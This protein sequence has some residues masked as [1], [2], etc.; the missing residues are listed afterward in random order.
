MKMTGGMGIAAFGIG[1]AGC[2]TTTA[3]PTDK[4]SGA[5]TAITVPVADAALMWVAVDQGYYNDYFD[6]ITINDSAGSGA[7]CTDAVLG[8][9]AFTG[10]SSYGSPVKMAAEGTGAKFLFNGMGCVNEIG[11]VYNNQLL[12]ARIDDDSVT[13]DFH[14]WEGK[15]VGTNAPGNILEF[16]VREIMDNAGADPNSITIVGAGGWGGIPALLTSRT[17]DLCPMIEP[18]YSMNKDNIKE[19]GAFYS[20][21][22]AE[23][24]IT[25][26]FTT[27]EQIATT[28]GAMDAFVATMDDDYD[29]WSVT[30]NLDAYYNFIADH[31][32]M[33]YEQ[34]A[35]GKQLKHFNYL[36]Y[37]SI[38]K[39]GDL[40]KKY[41]QITADVPDACTELIYEGS[42]SNC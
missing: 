16:S 7:A 41:G 21:M 8:G 33:S 29:F 19:I 23:S 30:A 25:G 35:T 13:S 32:G 38:Q 42:N 10:F 36:D 6:N 26:F 37:N 22:G 15:T 14:T 1:F 4:Y 24:Q 27:D 9:S 18:M 11:N 5:V 34:A 39:Q 2:E 12:T 20:W 3:A 40:M 17:V 31:T 28:A